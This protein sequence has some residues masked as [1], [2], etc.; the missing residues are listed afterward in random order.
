MLDAI[1]QPL[2]PLT[3][4]RFEICSSNFFIG[5]AI[6]CRAAGGQTS[7]LVIFAFPKGICSKLDCNFFVSVRNGMAES[8]DSA[9]RRNAF[10]R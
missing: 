4:K 8:E 9:T 7:L 5:S 2:Y 10:Q 6:P 3:S 1:V